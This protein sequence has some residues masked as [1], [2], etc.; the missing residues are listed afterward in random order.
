M[1]FGILKFT[2]CFSLH[3]LFSLMR[4]AWLKCVIKFS[5]EKKT[6]RWSKNAAKQ[7]W[8]QVE[9]SE[10]R[11][12][13]KL[14]S[15]E[16][17]KTKLFIGNDI[18]IRANKKWMQKERT[19]VGRPWLPCRSNICFLSPNS[20]I[21]I[22]METTTRVESAA[23]ICQWRERLFRY[24]ARK[25]G[26]PLARVMPRHP[27]LVQRAFLSSCASRSNFRTA[28]LWSFQIPHLVVWRM[29]RSACWWSIANYQWKIGVSSVTAL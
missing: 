23:N 29:A 4:G 14:K 27:F 15:A 1:E 6:Q 11:H 5:K 25:N 18:N 28:L 16:G 24:C 7:I 20:P 19:V 17:S 2:L 26:W 22:P 9:S 21:H 12:L 10:N 13:K 3:V 8:W